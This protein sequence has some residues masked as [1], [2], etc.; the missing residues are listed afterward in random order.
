MHTST[1]QQTR[2]EFSVD[3]LP[4]ELIGEGTLPPDDRV[5][6]SNRKVPVAAPD[7]QMMGLA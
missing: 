6:T 1:Q 2:E 5:A 7:L 3:T 4:G